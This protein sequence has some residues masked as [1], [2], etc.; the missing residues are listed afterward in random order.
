M[1]T[2]IQWCTELGVGTINE[3]S[4]ILVKRIDDFEVECT[5]NLGISL[6][7]LCFLNKNISKINF[8]TT[9]TNKGD[10]IKRI[11]EF[12]EEWKGYLT[13]CGVNDA[14]VEEAASILLK[15]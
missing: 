15:F 13:E 10:Q 8:L 2:D 14:S 3:Q 4:E 11:H 12:D 5:K 1:R 6:F 9:I 7:Y